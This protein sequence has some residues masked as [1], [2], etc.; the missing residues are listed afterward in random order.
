MKKTRDMVVYCDEQY[1][2]AF[3]T[4]V[5]REDGELIATFR[6]APNRRPYGTPG[7]SHFDTNAQ[8][9]LVRSRDGA[10]TWSAEPELIHAHPMGGC[11]TTGIVQL[12]D[13]ALLCTAHTWILVPDSKADGASSP[14]PTFRTQ[15]GSDWVS[16][17]YRHMGWCYTSAGG[18]LVRSDDGG[19]HW[20]GPIL[21]AALPGAR[22][23]DF[24]FKGLLSPLNRGAPI[25]G[26]DGRVYWSVVR[27]DLGDSRAEAADATMTGRATV[28]SISNHLIV[29]E[30]GGLNWEYR[31]PVAIDPKM[32][33]NEA[34]LYETAGG[35]LVAFLRTEGFDDHM[36]VARSRDGGHSFEPW[37]DTGIQGHPPQAVRLH[38]GRVLLVYGY[39]H[40]PFGVR[41]RVLNPDCTNIADAPEIVLRDDAATADT[42]YPWAA[43]LPDGRA[44]V[45]YYIH[46]DCPETARFIGATELAPDG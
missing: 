28:G 22:L 44:V 42:G 11:G 19:E 14:Y 32:I 23:A 40:R 7:N 34:S 21:P 41:A 36:V 13:G 9:V 3:P 39:R 15:S 26:S 37:E 29:S 8:A 30:D 31:C 4:V 35:D 20:R 45:V 5:C 10:E 12:S 18:H 25:E 16:A 27:Q 6:R 2:S 46:L 33:F 38:D 43:V 1:Y 24:F 17:V